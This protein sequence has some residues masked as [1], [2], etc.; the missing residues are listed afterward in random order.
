[1]PETKYTYPFSAFPNTK[2]NSDVLTDQIKASAIAQTLARIDTR[3]DGAALRQC[4][5][6]FADA[7]PSQ[8]ALDAIVAAHQGTA[9]VRATL[10]AGTTAAGVGTVITGIAAWQVLHG[11]VTSPEFF[12]KNLARVVGRAIGQ[13]KT[14]G[15]GVELKLVEQVGGI[16]RDMSAAFAAPDTGGQWQLFVFD[17]NTPPTAGG[18]HVYRLEAR[19]N[20]AVA[21][22]IRFAS[23][24]LLV[25]G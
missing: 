14:S 17:S 13:I 3:D 4:D 12:S 23:L 19:L 1:M 10:V 24:S 15:V 8:A 5:V 25:I 16:D 9:S 6:V 18:P 7:L 2:V 20:G 21:G 22:E 11:V